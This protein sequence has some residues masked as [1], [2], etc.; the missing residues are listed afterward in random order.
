MTIEQRFSTNPHYHKVIHGLFEMYRLAKEGKFESAEA[1]A[2]RDAMDEPWE[3]LND[4]EKQRARELSVELNAIIE[5]CGNKGLA[6]QL[7]DK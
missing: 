1:D 7:G 2:V 3:L 5:S 6:P 4:A